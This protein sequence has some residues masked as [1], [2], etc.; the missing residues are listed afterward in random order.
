[1]TQ[2]RNSWESLTRIPRRWIELY[3]TL[4]EYLTTLIHLLYIYIYICVK[5]RCLERLTTYV[6]KDNFL[7]YKD[8]LKKEL[9]DE[10]NFLCL[11][12]Y[13]L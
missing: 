7:Y 8:F 3:N 9:N 6:V 2:S 4:R 5:F 10:I 12:I 13:P 11:L 1:M